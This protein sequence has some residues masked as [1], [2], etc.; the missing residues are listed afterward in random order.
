MKRT[1]SEA[2]LK[3]I[4]PDAYLFSDI[5]VSY[6]TPRLHYFCH[7]TSE[8]ECVFYILRKGMTTTIKLTKN[9]AETMWIHCPVLEKEQ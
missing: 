4:M 5:V 1:H 2:K 3:R 8:V 6:R 9:Y 7:G